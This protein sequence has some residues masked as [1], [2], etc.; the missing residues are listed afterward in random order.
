MIRV[1]DFVT[2]DVPQWAKR[3]VERKK[4]LDTSKAE[5]FEYTEGLCVQ[6][7][8]IGPYDS[9]PETVEKMHNY[10]HSHTSS[11]QSSVS[12]LNKKIM[13]RLSQFPANF[14]ARAV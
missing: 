9:E 2:E 11:K 7:M 14:L 3:Q 5:L 13:C 8:H 6:A 12:P 10:A 1:P 4:K